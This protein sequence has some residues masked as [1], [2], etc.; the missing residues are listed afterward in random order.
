[1]RRRYK[2][3]CSFLQENHFLLR[4][5]HCGAA[6]VDCLGEPPFHHRDELPQ[7]VQERLKIAFPESVAL[8]IDARHQRLDA[9][10]VQRKGFL[11]HCRCRG[12]QRLLQF[13]LLSRIRETLADGLT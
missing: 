8:F 11:S 12:L 1:M 3:L 5:L 10:P 7:I 4:R 13:L 6:I 9:A 2:F